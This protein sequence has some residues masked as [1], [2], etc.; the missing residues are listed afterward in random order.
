MQVSDIVK[1]AL[2]IA[3]AVA[4]IVLIVA[5]PFVQ[6]ID[7][8]EFGA[9]I[10]NVVSVVGSAFAKARGLIN[11]F[12]SP[13]GRTLLTGILVYLFGKWAITIGIKITAWIYH[14]IFK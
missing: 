8:G 5:L 14:F 2:L 7:F 9:L 12:L 13:F 11:S 4:L 3:G 6:F 1:W 10:S